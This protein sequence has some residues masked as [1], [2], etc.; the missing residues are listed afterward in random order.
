MADTTVFTF[1]DS[2]GLAERLARGAGLPWRPVDVR[3][4]PDG[5]SLVRVSAATDHVVLVRSLYHPTAKIFEVL[6]AASALRDNGAKTITLVAPYLGYMRQDKAF[7]DGEAV[8][9]RVMGDVIGRYVD[10]VVA[11]EPH[12][13]RTHDLTAVFKGREALAISGAPA[14]AAAM[15]AKLSH[16]TVV[17]GPDEE[18][19]PLAKTVAAPLN[20]SWTVGTKVRHGDR[21]V[22]LTLPDNVTLLGKPVLIVDDIISSGVTI[23]AA[24]QAAQARGA[25]QVRVACVHALFDNGVMADFHQT[26]IVSV[27][28]GDGAPHAATSF[29][30]DQ[31]IIAAMTAKGW[32]T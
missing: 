27:D 1:A 22:S 25:S 31:T 17:I 9:Q 13:H 20:L 21:K 24:A 23:L 10:R 29:S 26:G 28:A 8:S 5:E 16:D 2:Q 6:L 30:L 14:V 32:L 3:Q 19:A 18:S 15:A 12:L 11:V 4:F 7:H